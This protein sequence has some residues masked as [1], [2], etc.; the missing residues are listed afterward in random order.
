M[1]GAQPLEQYRER[2]AS[3][4]QAYARSLQL[5]ARISYGRLAAVGVTAAC[6]WLAYLGLLS[7]WWI[8]PPISAFLVLLVWHDRVIRAGQ[9]LARAIEFYERGIARIEDRWADEGG[10]TEQDPPYVLQNLN[11]ETRRSQSIN[12]VFSSYLG[13]PSIGAPPLPRMRAAAYSGFPVPQMR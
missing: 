4:R 6:A 1:A 12:F 10:S 3:R 2:L 7:W 13:A 11:A 5:D 9:A 8:A